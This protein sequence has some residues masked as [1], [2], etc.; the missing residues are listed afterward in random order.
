MISSQQG[1]YPSR[2]QA[3]A[4]AVGAGSMSGPSILRELMLQKHEIKM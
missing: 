4:N 2:K 3:F 1:E